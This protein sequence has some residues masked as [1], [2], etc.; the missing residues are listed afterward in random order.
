M[1]VVEKNWAGGVH[2]AAVLLAFGTHW[3][4]GSGGMLA[5]FIVW[6]LKREESELIRSHASE[7]FNFNLSMS[8]YAAVGLFFVLATLGFGIVLYLPV[9]ALLAVVWIWCTLRAA[10]AGFDG[11]EY[12]YPFTIRILR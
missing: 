2:V 8:L 7:A 4:A 9:A 1:S 6:L 10:I 3:F 5:G 12:R 11:R